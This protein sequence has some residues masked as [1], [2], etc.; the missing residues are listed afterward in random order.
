MNYI[1]KLRFARL[2][3]WHGVDWPAYLFVENE[4]GWTFLLVVLLLVLLL[5]S[6]WLN[7]VAEFCIGLYFWVNV[8]SFLRKTSEILPNRRYGTVSRNIFLNI[9]SQKD[10]HVSAPCDENRIGFY[11]TNNGN[12]W[13]NLVR[14]CHR[15][16]WICTQTVFWLTFARNNREKM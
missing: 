1:V 14:S 13:K 11:Q 2:C 5:L 9:N 7:D 10:D 6:S 4:F 16:K 3:A 8:S 15:W 12:N